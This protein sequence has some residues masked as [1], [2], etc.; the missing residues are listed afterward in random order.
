MQLF[1]SCYEDTEYQ[2]NHIIKMGGQS[3]WKILN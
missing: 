2:L 3:L 1:I